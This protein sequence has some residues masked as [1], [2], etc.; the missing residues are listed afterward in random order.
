MDLLVHARLL[1]QFRD[2]L[3][4]LLGP[5]EGLFDRFLLVRRQQPGFLATQG[6]GC[7]ELIV[8]LVDCREQASALFADGED[9]EDLFGDF[10]RGCES[11]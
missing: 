9:L 7:C 2:V 10:D 3:E 11:A 6:F 5:R 4:S 8:D 1:D